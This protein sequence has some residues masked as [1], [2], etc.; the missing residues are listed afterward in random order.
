MSKESILE[1]L[2]EV[3]TQAGPSEGG[4]LCS[5]HIWLSAVSPAV[6]SAFEDVLYYAYVQAQTNRLN[7]LRGGIEQEPC[8]LREGVVQP[9]HGADRR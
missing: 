3:T 5:V 9:S 1:Q 6:T 7:S 2:V 4:G 8:H